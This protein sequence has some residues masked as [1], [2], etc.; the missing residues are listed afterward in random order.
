LVLNLPEEMEEV[1]P[2]RRKAPLALN[3][4]VYPILMTVAIAAS[5]AFAT[6]V[7]SPVNTLALGPGGY[8]FNDFGVRC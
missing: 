4:S 3:I 5:T 6:P 1:A 8:K 7:A 2:S